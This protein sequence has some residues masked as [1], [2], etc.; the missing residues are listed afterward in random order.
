M[1]GIDLW[2]ATRATGVAALVLLTATMVLGILVAGRAEGSLPPV[3]RA[4]THRCLSAITV[5]F[6]A[7][8]VLTSVVDTYVHLG[9]ASIVVPFTSS[10]DRLWV[11]IGTVGLDLFLAVG[12]S[13]M[14]RQRISA[15]AWRLFHWLA[16]LSWPT[17]VAHTLGM[18]TDTRLAWVIGLVGLCC[19]SVV[20]AAA[21]RVN[22]A[23]RARS[24]RPMTI[25]TP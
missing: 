24:D 12:V 17:A 22:E 11:A 1:N 21:W 20:A 16:Y 14:L 18:G 7:L 8:H 4:E 25:L 23:V 3:L 5:V 10:Y 6:L 9:W 13:S 2:Y 15:R 19:A